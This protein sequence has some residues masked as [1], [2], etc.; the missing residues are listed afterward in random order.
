[1]KSQNENNNFKL[2]LSLFPRIF[3]EQLNGEELTFTGG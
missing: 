2:F 1:M 3:E